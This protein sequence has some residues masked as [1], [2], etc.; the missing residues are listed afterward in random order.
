M[1][2][3]AD[4]DARGGSDRREACPHLGTEDDISSRQLGPS[5]RHRCYR[6]MQC[7]R[8]DLQYQASFCLT[9]F[10]SHC[11]WLSISA[12]VGT[13]PA[14]RVL[15]LWDAARAIGARVFARAN[16]PVTPYWARLR[17]ALARL[18]RALAEQAAAYW[19]G[20]SAD[21]PPESIGPAEELADSAALAEPND[22]PEVK[23]AGAELVEQGLLAM[24]EGRREEA[25]AMFVRA[26]EVDPTFEQ[27]WLWRAALSGSADDK[28]ECLEQILRV[29]P[30]STFAKSALAMLDQPDASPTPARAADPLRASSSAWPPGRPVSITWQCAACE[31]VNTGQA[32]MCRSC[33]SPSPEVEEELTSSGDMLLA[34]GLAGL[35]AGNEELAYRHFVMACKASPKSE[36]AW[37]WR[38]KTAPTLDE[39]IR[40]LEHL[41]KL[42]P[43]DAKVQADLS[44]ALQRQAHE[45]ALLAPHSQPSAA[46]VSLGRAAARLRRRIE[47]LRW[48]ILQ[49][50]GI[51]AFLLALGLTIPYVLRIAGPPSRPEVG[52]YLALLPA[53]SPPELMMRA[54]YVPAL[55]LG[56]A[57]PAVIGL[58]LLHAAFIVARGG[59]LGTRA[60]TALLSA[61]VVGMMLGF[62]ANPPSSSY[63]AALAVAAALSALA[64]DAG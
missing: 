30:A 13:E 45:R 63:A 6:W 2:K 7:E 56:P 50:A 34:Q 27:G 10:H 3:P 37:H 18:G 9:E 51:S 39:V 42:N 28:R 61:A 25:Y 4:A 21:A 29:N 1:D 31:T 5:P 8:I 36:L 62:G 53:V 17:T 59:G 46:A 15:G 43:G 54:P 19:R 11:Y 16:A 38:A 48:W 55:D 52:A 12:P 47:E 14:T 57:L 22:A 20:A 49:F 40:C 58:L 64:G 24:R 26:S 23:S 60:W 32:R 41:L 44:S 33:G 35:K